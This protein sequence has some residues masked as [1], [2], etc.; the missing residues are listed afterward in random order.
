[1][2]E[3]TF[4]CN[5]WLSGCSFLGKKSLNGYNLLLSGNLTRSGEVIRQLKNKLRRTS[6]A[7]G[8]RKLKHAISSQIQNSA[9]CSVANQGNQPLDLNSRSRMSSSKGS[10]YF[11]GDIVLS[12]GKYKNMWSHKAYYKRHHLTNLSFYATT[13]QDLTW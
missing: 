11:N 13:G 3:R 2:R 9:S 10:L 4:D 1:M 8:R 5:C 12:H 6:Y 7:P